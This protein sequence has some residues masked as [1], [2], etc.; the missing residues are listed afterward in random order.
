MRIRGRVQGVFFRASCARQAETLG[1]AGSVRNAA[2]G[3]VEAV[4][5]GEAPAV[6]A[7]MRWCR[8]GPAG[9]RVDEVVVADEAPEGV[10]GFVVTG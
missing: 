1:V 5:E 6:E 3:S 10:E 2:D 7:I 9:A 4:F 8:S